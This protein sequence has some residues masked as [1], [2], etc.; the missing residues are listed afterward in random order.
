MSVYLIVVVELLRCVH[1]RM[2]QLAMNS[3]GHAW[4]GLQCEHAMNQ[5]STIMGRGAYDTT[6]TRKPCGGV[7]RKLFVSFMPTR[8]LSFLQ[9]RSLCANLLMC[10]ALAR[11]H[12]W[13]LIEG[14]MYMYMYDG[15]TFK[16]TS[17]AWNQDFA[18]LSTTIALLD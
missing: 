3:E 18:R 2:L 12:H 10:T 16:M 9:G 7:G 15:K 14:Y 8:V 11:P 1:V 13:T 5:T 17:E 4:C 6:G